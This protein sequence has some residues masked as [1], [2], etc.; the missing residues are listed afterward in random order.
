[1][2]GK[3]RKKT[4]LYG[5]MIFLECITWGIGNPLISVGTRTIPTFYYIAFR[6]LIAFLLFFLCF[7]KRTFVNFKKVKTVPLVMI[8]LT[9]AAAFICCNA[10]LALPDANVTVC[11]FLFSI[12]VIFTPFIAC[13]VFKSRLE[14]KYIF[15]IVIVTV[16]LALICGIGKGEFSFALPEAL[17]V[18]CAL[19]VSVS[20]TLTGKY[21]RSSDPVSMSAIMCLFC[22]VISITA[23]LI[24]EKPPALSDIGAS[25]YVSIL[26][27][28]VGSTF[29]AYVLQNT[30]LV[31]LS[32]TYVSLVLCAE[33]V[34]TAIASYFMLGEKLDFLGY[35]GAALI[36]AAI[37]S[38]SVIAE[39]GNRSENLY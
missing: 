24:F 34:F 37:F 1:M 30:A 19:F 13:M 36:M 27:V 33:P 25:G 31:H 32:P 14:T 16:G 2:E 26:Y 3:S 12:S 6:F 28:S 18:I 22:F 20:I 11:G 5:G 23:A 10:A 9:N 38:A 15:P 29:L 8:C 39:R 4:A 7:G 35:I 17:A 21:V